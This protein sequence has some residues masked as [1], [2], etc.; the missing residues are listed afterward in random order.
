MAIAYKSQGAG[1]ST[2][3][4]GANLVPLCPATVDAGDILLAH[5]VVLDATSALSTP[6][7]WTLLFGPS[8]LGTGTPTGRAWAYGKIADGT[9]DGAGIN[10]GSLASTIGRLGRIYSF[11]G[12][13]SGT[14]ADIIPAASF[15]ANSSETD[16][17]IQAVT[18]TIGGAKAVAL[19][20]QDDNNSH[21]GLGAV[22]DGTWVEAVAD[23]V[24]SAV[25]PQ[26]ACLQIQVGT[27]TANPGTIS[28]GTVAGTNDEANTLNFE[29]RPE[30]LSNFS[31]ADGSASGS[32]A[33]TSVAVVI[34]NTVIA[35]AGLATSAIVGSALWLGVAASAG[36]GA[37]P[38][39]GVSLVV[40]IVESGGSTA[41]SGV[42]GSLS[43]GTASAS[44]IAADA[45]TT[46]SIAS[47]A[48]ES[49]G[50]GTA[51]GTAT[52]T[53]A[54]DGASSG[55][56]TSSGIGASM[57]ASDSASVGLGS[58]SGIGRTSIFGVTRDGAGAALGNCVVQLFRTSD[59]AFQME[60][61]SSV[62]GNYVLYPDVAGPFYIVAY[63]TGSPDLTG[64]TINTLTGA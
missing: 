2:E 41:S 35:A 24:D 45:V 19:I 64:A 7:G 52:N 47:V 56:G 10:F 61:A 44:G 39:I 30:A 1:I 23:Y 55:A 6:S 27:P 12:Y 31:E 29:I 37:A 5:I 20:S 14:I 8:G 51:L 21:D 58:A 54:A 63:K 26:G 62:V 50:L 9:E 38:G 3:T 59:D 32:A 46:G 43:A 11:S 49:A 33:V 16:P 13:V 42:G 40:S 53:E 22:S 48:A 60:A 18:T 15:T 36:V 17:I 57:A 25:G 4:S 34:W 28:G